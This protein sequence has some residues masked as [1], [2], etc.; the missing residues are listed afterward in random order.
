MLEL[1]GFQHVA[2]PAA[3][4]HAAGQQVVAAFSD[5][6]ALLPRPAE[7]PAAPAAIQAPSLAAVAVP[8]TAAA[9]AGQRDGLLNWLRQLIGATL[10]IEPARIAGDQTLERYGIDS[11]TVQQI[12][13]GLREVFDDV[14]ASLLFEHN[15]LD[16]LA[17]HFLARHAAAVAALLGEPAGVPPQAAPAAAA[18]NVAD[19]AAPLA[20][21]A[22]GQADAVAGNGEIAVIGL[23]GRYPHAATLD[24]LWQLLRSGRS[25]IGEIPAERWNWRDYAP[26]AAGG[27][28]PISSRYGGFIDDIDR[29]DPLFFQIAMAEAHNMDPQERLFVEQAYCC[30][31]DA[32]HVP[33]TLSRDKRVGVYVGVMNANYPTGVRHW[34]IANRIS[35]LFDFR[36]PS[37][38]LDSACSSSLTALHLALDALRAGSIDCALVG[39]VNLVTDPAHYQ[40]LSAMNMLSDGPQ[41]RAFGARANGFVDGEGV[42]AM[43]LKPLRQALADGDD[44]YGVLLGSA[45]NAGGKTHGYTVPSPQ[46]QADVVA[47]AYQQAGVTPRMVSYVEAHGTGTALGDP[48]E[49]RGLTLAFERQT[50]E[51]QFCA[52]GSVKTNIGHTESAAGIAGVTKVLLQMKH[53]MLAPTLHAEQANPEIDFARTPFRLQHSLQAWDA[54]AQG[55]ARIASVSS[56]GA[57]GANA[58]VVLR[59]HVS[60]PPDGDAPRHEV[61]V[62]LSARDPERLLARARQLLA[63]LAQDDLPSDA[64]QRIA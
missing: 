21:G 44:I 14:P 39:G 62:L 28:A 43:L 56:F 51:R 9:T 1:S 18:S 5:G 49:V 11:I 25:A 35:Y 61:L 27:R 48:I 50:Q 52:L 4:A 29:F 64:L 34:S 58:A 55:G 45:L 59:E 37:M 41:V 22:A 6:V 12:T 16:A 36:G 7:T 30:I 26:G 31:E 8:P 38:A 40:R 15:T 57:G 13:S 20:A 2:F 19:G 47:Q 10:E 60:P 32:G 17:E 54:P 23:A 63:L 33:A 3:A 46:A 42:G 53:R 24:E